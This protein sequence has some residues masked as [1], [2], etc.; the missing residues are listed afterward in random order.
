[1]PQVLE[2]AIGGLTSCGPQLRSSTVPSP[3]L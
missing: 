2:E 1:M 3:L